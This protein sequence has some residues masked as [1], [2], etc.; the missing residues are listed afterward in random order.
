MDSDC[1]QIKEC[2]IGDG[3]EIESFTVLTDCEI[4]SDCLIWR[5]VNMYGC[6]LGDDCMI[7]SLVEIQSDVSVGDRS[8]IQSHAFLCSKVTIG[9]DVFVSHGAM[10]V[11]DRYPPSG[12]EEAWESTV[13]H[14]GAVIGT[15][16]TLMP[17]DV[18]ENALVGAGAVVVED[19]PANA[20]VAGNPAEVVGYR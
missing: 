10:F 7:G 3:T 19:V 9:E 4:G 2:E 6:T 15:N 13:V 1:R 11:N 18:G 16:A 20:I 12:D 8:R 14:D 17:V 5:F